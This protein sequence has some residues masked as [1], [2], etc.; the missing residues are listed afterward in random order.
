[1]AAVPAKDCEERDEGVEG[2]QSSETKKQCWGEDPGCRESVSWIEDANI[3][4]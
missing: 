3:G 4:R 1:M 2:Q